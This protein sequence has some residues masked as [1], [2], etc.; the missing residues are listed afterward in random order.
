MRW[1]EQGIPQA[2]Q[3][4][5]VNK[6]VF[7]VFISGDNDKSRE[8]ESF[9]QSEE[10]TRLCEESQSVAIKLLSDGNDVK[11]FSQIYPVVVIP[12]V[13]FISDSGMPLEVI[14]ECQSEEDFLSKVKNAL[15]LQ[16]Q[17]T[18]SGGGTTQQPTSPAPL[19]STPETVAA[20]ASSQP[21][22]SGATATDVTNEELNQKET[23][24]ERV[25]KAKL[26]LE[27]KR[28]EKM[29]KEAEEAR[30][31]E[32]ERR[33]IGQGVQKL[34]EK[35]KEMDILEA[36]KEL[37]KEKDEEKLARQR[38]K[39]E[40]ERDRLEKAAR[41]GKEKDAQA[42]AEEALKKKR[43]AEQQ[44]AEAAELARRSDIARIQF[45]LSDGSSVTQQFPATE[46]F[47]AVNAFISQ[48]TGAQVNLSMAFPRRTFTTEDLNLT[49]QELQLAPSA[50]ILVIPRSTSTS[51]VRSSSGLL[52]VSGITNLL[53]SPF[54]FVW[55]IFSSLFGS[56]RLAVQ[57]SSTVQTSARGGERNPGS[58]QKR[59]ASSS[60]QEG[61]VRRF[62]NA[63]DDENDEDRNTWNG[64]STQQM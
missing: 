3:A 10:V 44:A 4:A 38:V 62:R 56:T 61:S 32:I 42:K 41:F 58:A 33:N 29:R 36:K 31:R 27:Q 16:A 37:K 2:I 20:S 60:R 13:F 15:Q 35:Q 9:L 40:I 64:N 63:Q 1:F 54:F 43:L 24:E 53:L 28:E 14:G 30:Q 49:L 34:R 26:L 25:E 52:S 50:V 12:S 8:M 48:H 59:A 6:S 18:A 55:K 17:S 21:P 45:R 51:V 39:E 22:A 11:F 47:A 5:K 23:L 57:T 7:I 46:K 19:P